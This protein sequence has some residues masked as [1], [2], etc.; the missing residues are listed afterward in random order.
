MQLLSLGAGSNAVQRLR[1]RPRKGL[2][3]IREV[4]ERHFQ[5]LIL[6]LT[7]GGFRPSHGSWY[8]LGVSGGHPCFPRVSVR[9]KL[10]QIS[11]S[12]DYAKIP[13]KICHCD[14]GILRFD[15]W[16]RGGCV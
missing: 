9:H 4:L 12:E 15:G 1:M 6:R 10:L 14:F 3:R 11:H 5:P 16:I 7:F 8:M 13:L 2:T